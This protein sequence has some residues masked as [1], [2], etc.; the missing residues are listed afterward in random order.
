MGVGPGELSCLKYSSKN[1]FANIV[2]LGKQELSVNHKQISQILSVSTKEA[3]SIAEQKYIN[4]LLIDKLGAKSVSSLDNSDFENADIIQDLNIPLKKCHFNKFETVLDIGTLEHVF[5]VPQA[6]DNI[7]KLATINGQ[8]IHCL[9]SEGCCGHGFYQF[10]PELFF[11]IYSE[12][13][14]FINTEIFLYE[15]QREATWYK[16]YKVNKPNAGKRIELT[17]HFKSQP[18]AIFVKTLKVSETSIKD[19]QQSDYSYKWNKIIE[20]TNSKQLKTNPKS[21][22]LKKIKAN[23]SSK[24]NPRLLKKLFQVL[25]VLK[26]LKKKSWYKHQYI[27]KVDARKLL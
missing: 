22:F 24:L 12:E 15:F 26:N 7:S 9:P 6:L 4:H 14:G 11:N 19:V 23:I 20:N 27:L 1:P 25:K 21:L 5:N 13:N 17:N 18:I 10:S 2:T 3:K 8:I 16:W